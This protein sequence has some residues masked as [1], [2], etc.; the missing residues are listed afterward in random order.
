MSAETKQLFDQLTED[1]MML[2]DN[3]DYSS[4]YSL[5]VQR[6]DPGGK[7]TDIFCYFGM[8]DVYNEKQETF[9][10]EA[11][12]VSCLFMSKQPLPYLFW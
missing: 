6:L 8:A 5:S 9:Q 1:A 7:K 4:V 11:G 10:R 12:M 2:M 3:G